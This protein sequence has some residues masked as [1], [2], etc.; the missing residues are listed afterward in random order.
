MTSLGK[1]KV[2]IHS[3]K[4]N[5]TGKHKQNK[6]NKKLRV[7]EQWVL[8]QISCATAHSCD[9]SLVEFSM[10]GRIVHSGTTFVVVIVVVDMVG[11]GLSPVVQGLLSVL[12][13]YS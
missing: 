11:L 13:H 12:Y 8:M 10:S 6:E 1:R 4:I 2:W 3:S 9:L 7:K 5:F